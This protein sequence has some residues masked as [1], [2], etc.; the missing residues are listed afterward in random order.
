MVLE[1]VAQTPSRHV[2]LLTLARAA[3]ALA[4]LCWA[5]MAWWSAPRESTVARLEA[6]FN[7][8]TITSFAV[9]DHSQGRNLW[10]LNYDRSSSE[11]KVTWATRDGHTHYAYRAWIPDDDV[12]GG[13]RQGADAVVRELSFSNLAGSGLSPFH[14]ISKTM[15]WFLAFIAL[16]VLLV[17]P[18]PVR[19]TRPFW[20]WVGQL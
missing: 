17:A 8:G 9:G 16:G 11:S 1:E 2:R 14:E 6:D 13:R 20:F 19:G 18:D 10:S 15:V 3:L 5:A 7:A 12:P 4:W